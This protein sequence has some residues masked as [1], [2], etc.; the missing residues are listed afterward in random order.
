MLDYFDVHLEEGES[1]EMPGFPWHPHKGMETISYFLRGG[2]EYQDSMGNKGIFSQ[3][4]PLRETIAWRGPIV[5]NTQKERM[6]TFRDLEN[7]TF[8]IED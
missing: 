6:A 3:G 8:I 7:D 5:M 4:R 1:Y 2:G